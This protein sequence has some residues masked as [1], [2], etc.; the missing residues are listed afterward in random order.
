[1][2]KQNP[3]KL[4]AGKTT[5]TAPVAQAQHP[6]R[7]HVKEDVQKQNSFIWFRLCIRLLVRGA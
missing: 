7:I 6:Q 1:M 3:S 4:E 2:A 5:K